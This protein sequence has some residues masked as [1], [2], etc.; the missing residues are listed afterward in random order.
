MRLNSDDS[1]KAFLESL[2]NIVTD[3]IFISNKTDSIKNE[4]QTNQWSISLPNDIVGHLTDSDLLSFLQ[5]IIENRQHQLNSSE[6]QTDLIFY[7]W[8]DHQARQIRLCVI[9]CS[10]K[11]LPFNK[12]IVF[13]NL[14]DIVKDFLDQKNHEVIP[15]NETKEMKGPFSRRNSMKNPIHVSKIILRKGQK[16]PDISV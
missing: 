1:V 6:F 3:E 7:S 16:A 5:K 11:E 12:P 14:E 10:H 13:K 8:V 4:I 9:N 15:S 2:Q